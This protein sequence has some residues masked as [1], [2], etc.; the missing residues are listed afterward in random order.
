MELKK[1][2]RE[3]ADPHHSDEETEA[4]RSDAARTDQPPEFQATLRAASWAHRLQDAAEA[5]SLVP[6]PHL[7]SPV[8]V[9]ALDLP[10]EMA[11]FL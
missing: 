11:L 8:L 5:V 2:I 4:R 10:G 6:S 3:L 9:L 1:D 7:L